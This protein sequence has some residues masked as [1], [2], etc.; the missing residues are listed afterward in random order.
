MAAYGVP[1]LCGAS[2]P[3]RQPAELLSEG[4]ASLVPT[5]THGR[6]KTSGP[7]RPSVYPLGQAIKASSHLKMTSG[8]LCHTRSRV[9]V[10]PVE[11]HLPLAS[12]GTRPY[13]FHRLNIQIID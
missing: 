6:L 7:T 3:V 5:V 9:W 12:T 1:S 13:T 11:F 10:G 8:G 4:T 2:R